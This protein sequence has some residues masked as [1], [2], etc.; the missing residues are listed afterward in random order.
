LR[1]GGCKAVQPGQ[2]ESELALKVKKFTIG[3]KDVPNPVADNAES[4]PFRR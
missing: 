4:C 1:F 2:A 3:G